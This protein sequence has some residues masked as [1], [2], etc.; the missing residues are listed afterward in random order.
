[1]WEM[2]MNT[3]TLFIKGKLFRN[4][5]GVF[6]RSVVGVLIGVVL[7]VAIGK[8]LGPAYWWV[9][10]LIGGAVTGFLMP[11]MFKDLKYA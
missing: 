1:M 5:A 11:Y 6:M 10:A 3:V 2:F 9:G 8:L 7:L 4:P